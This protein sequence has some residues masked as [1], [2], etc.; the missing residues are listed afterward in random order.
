MRG[1]SFSLQ[2]T[3]HSIINDLMCFVSLRLELMECYDRICGLGETSLSV[4]GPQITTISLPNLASDMKCQKNVIN[5]G[6][7]SLLPTCAE[8][9]KFK[10]DCWDR[11]DYAR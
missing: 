11:S 6:Q 7:K 3:P 1:L 5:S 9:S 2:S 10:K 8:G 4:Q